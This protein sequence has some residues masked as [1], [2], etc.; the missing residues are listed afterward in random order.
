MAAIKPADATTEPSFSEVVFWHNENLWAGKG[1]L[2]PFGKW[3][4]VMK[5]LI[6]RDEKE[7]VAASWPL[8]W[9]FPCTKITKE[10]A[11][12]FFSES[13]PHLTLRL[14][15][16][17][18]VLY[19]HVARHGK[20]G[21]A[22]Y[23]EDVF[24]KLFDDDVERFLLKF[25]DAVLTSPGLDKDPKYQDP[26]EAL[27]DFEV[28]FFNQEVPEYQY[29]D[30]PF[31]DEKTPPFILGLAYAEDDI[32]AIENLQNTNDT[33][34]LKNFTITSSIPKV[35][36]TKSPSPAADAKQDE[37]T[38]KAKEAKRS[39]RK[40]KRERALTDTNYEADRPRGP[41]AARTDGGK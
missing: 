7:L 8:H 31:V 18:Q 21:V 24:L 3:A 32:R 23:N 4:D 11:K 40:A 17:Y 16:T 5:K 26:D 35:R 10:E 1:N 28:A 6:V 27:G 36:K 30:V 12:Q 38:K 19:H 22:G 33:E 29:I 25:R 34:A 37:E 41:R 9:V 39:E 14:G 20:A 2:F 13:N 15:Y